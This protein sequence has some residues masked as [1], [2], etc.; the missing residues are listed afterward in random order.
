MIAVGCPIARFTVFAL[1]THD[2]DGVE[3]A[4][5]LG[6]DGLEFARVSVREVSLI[7][8][9]L[10][11]F[12]GERCHDQPVTTEWR[13]IRCK[14]FASVFFNC[15]LRL[16]GPGWGGSGQEFSCF[17]SDRLA[18]KLSTLSWRSR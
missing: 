12:D 3:K 17:E 8:S 4:A 6:D 11:F 15:R 13:A 1:F 2:D 10:D 5:Q 7:G 9:G 18:G 16:A 14:N